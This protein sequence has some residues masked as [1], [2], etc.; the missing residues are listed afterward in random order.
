MGQAQCGLTSP[1]QH[2][3]CPMLKH[4]ESIVLALLAEVLT[5]LYPEPAAYFRGRLASTEQGESVVV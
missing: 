4:L 3:D 5:Q 2:H 1:R